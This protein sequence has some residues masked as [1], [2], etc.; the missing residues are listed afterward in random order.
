MVL[1]VPCLN[2]LDLHS[3]T[4]SPSTL[5]ST[6]YQNSGWAIK[7]PNLSVALTNGWAPSLLL[8]EQR[9]PEPDLNEES[10]S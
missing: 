6:S 2:G 4:L 5:N 7:A 1:C 9:A 10:M 8:G 3:L